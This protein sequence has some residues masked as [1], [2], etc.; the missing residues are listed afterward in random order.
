MA[1]ATAVAHV[2][3]AFKLGATVVELRS[4]IA[5]AQQQKPEAL[6]PTIRLS[7]VWR[8]GFGQLASL[9]KTAFPKAADA[10]GVYEPPG[11]DKLPYLYPD[12]PDYANIGIKGED[13]A[14]PILSDFKLFDVTRRAINCLTVLYINQAESLIPDRIEQAQQRLIA[15]VLKAEAEQ[16]NGAVPLDA[17][18]V[19]D[20]L[21]AAKE[22][23][24]KRILK[25]LEAWDG[26]IRENYYAAGVKPNNELELIAYEAGFAMASMSW[27]LSVKTI[28]T[29]AADQ[30]EKAWKDAFWPQDVIR[31]QHQ[32]GTL[33]SVLDEAYLDAYY[34]QHP[35]EKRGQD[36]GPVLAAA[37]SRAIQAVKRSLAFWQRTVDLECQATAE[38]NGAR[39]EDLRRALIKQGNIW[40]TLMTGQQN[41]DAFTAE[42]VTQKIMSD[43]SQQLAQMTRADLPKALDSVRA[44]TKQIADEVTKQTEQAI[45][46]VR[47]TAV[48][49]W[50][51]IHGALGNV[52]IA[53]AI[54]VVVVIV[55]GVV[56]AFS[57]GGPSPTQAV[58]GTTGGSLVTALVTAIGGWFG[59]QKVGQTKEAAK[60]EIE[61]TTNAEKGKV[62]VK[63]Q[64]ATTEG[65]SKIMDTV[66]TLGHGMLTRAE[67]AAQ[68]AA[69]EIVAAFERAYAQVR[70]ELKRL[71]QTVA[72]SYPLLEYFGSAKRGGDE[73]FVMKVLWP[74]GDRKEQVE[75]IAR[76]ALGPLAMLVGSSADGQESASR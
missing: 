44:T 69:S 50:D 64:E 41:L 38:W 19:P 68:Q 4:R 18:P 43:V 24:T 20:T 15:A 5:I 59:L 47:K 55:I 9:L 40:Q 52:A 7:S 3:D 39:N 16:G 46:E 54:A 1:D 8:A 17:A 31:L 27:D 30:I 23:L 25:F 10:G 63:A 48:R 56:I 49:Q 72:I 70:E 74:E 75:R 42:T 67:G 53:V 26:Y 58:A 45:D 51:A 33:S 65:Q 14:G 13:D 29:T 22:I 28:S 61:T 71:G 36:D 12:A 76:A 2:H 11:K 62:Q 60:T 73:R 66:G 32:I 57:F 6:G 35:N 21:R 37:P 34:E